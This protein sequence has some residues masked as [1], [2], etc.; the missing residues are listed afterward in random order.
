MLAGNKAEIGHELS[1]IAEACDI[2]QF[3]CQ[4]RRG[5]QRQPPKRSQS[6]HDRRKRPLR[7]GGLNVG[8]KTITPRR[9]RFRR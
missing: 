9:G 8:F 3:G 7:D 5:D 1:G 2:P 4:R 6:L